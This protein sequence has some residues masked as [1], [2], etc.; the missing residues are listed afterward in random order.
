[1]ARVPRGLK[2]IRKSRSAPSRRCRDIDLTIEPGRVRLLPRPVG[3]RQDHAAAHHRRPRNA[4]RRQ[5]PSRPGR[6]ISRCRRPSATTA[7]SS[8]RTRC[9]PTSRSPTTSPTAWSTASVAQATIT[10]RVDGAAEAGR[11]ARQRREVPGAALRRAAAAHR[12]GAGARDLA[13]PAAAR[14]AAVGA[15]RDRTRAPAPGDPLAAA[16]ARRHDASWSR[17]TRKRRSRSPTASSS[18]N[19]G[20]IE[21]VGTPM[22][23]YRDP[24]TPFV[25]DFVGKINVLA[26]PPAAGRDLRV[27]ASRFACEHD[28]DAE[29][30][31]KVYLRPEDVLARPIAPGDVNV[32]DGAIDKIEFLGSYCLVRVNAEAIGQRADHRLPVAQLPR[33]AGPGGRQPAAAAS[34]AR[35]DALLLGGRE[36]RPV[37][38][39]LPLSAAR[40]AAPARPLDRPHRPCRAA[41]AGAGA[42]RL[43]GAAARRHPRQGAA[44][45]RRRRSSASPT[46]P[47]T[48]R[49]RRCC[50][51]FWNSVWVS[52]L[53]TADHGA[54]G[55]RLRLRD[56]AQ[57]HARAR[58]CSAPSRWCRCSRRRCSSAISLIY[59][60]GNQGI[61]KGVVT[62]LGFEN[63]YGAPGIVIAE[64]FAVFPHAL[65]ILVTRAR[66][67]RRAALR[68][69]ARRSAP[70]PGASS[71]PSRCRARSTA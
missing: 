40:A 11:P 62:A 19:Q 4:D 43:P 23:V 51:S 8:S 46:S 29:R 7:S 33:R 45:R 59:W 38:A 55:L 47:P 60:F 22:E 32:F 31:V 52:A 57:L 14:R 36:A 1:M 21:Q 5:H 34:A 53:V 18:M 42:G 27:G 64:C 12:A 15:R 70:P 58:A 10:A 61:A 26:G 41:G 30:D 13:R 17:T 6:D 44:E 2:D 66:A 3:L 24:A 56:D 69:G 49:R 63:I 16:Q 37:S 25:A 65:M 67:R 35:A 9:F 50:S 71:S 28:T 68:G 54:A 48:S 39:V 20:V